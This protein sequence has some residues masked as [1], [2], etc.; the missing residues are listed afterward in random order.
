[1]YKNIQYV[2]DNGEQV[3]EQSN[4]FTDSLS[5]EGYR[6]PSHKGGYRQFSNVPLPTTVHMEDWGRMLYIVKLCMHRNILGEFNGKTLIPFTIHEMA[7]RMPFIAERT[8]YRAIHHME[9]SGIVKQKNKIWYVN[10]AYFLS[11]GMRVSKELASLFY[12][13]IYKIVPAWA[14]REME[15]QKEGKI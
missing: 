3:S 15:I 9:K 10:P 4:Y 5:E 13:D 11:S 6:V 14:L 2:N 1:M 7:K 8:L 12:D